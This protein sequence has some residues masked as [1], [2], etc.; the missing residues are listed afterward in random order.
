MKSV[1]PIKPDEVAQA[2]A[3]SIPSEVF[4]AFNDQ[5]TLKFS[6][7]RALVMQEDVISA[8]ISKF[9]GSD[10]TV[11]R[12]RIFE[13]HWLDVEDAYRAVGWKVFYDKPAFNESY[14]ASFEFK[15]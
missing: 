7:N 13:K 8:I 14:P 2:K 9:P 15:K 6:G 12:K 5:I 4:E 10:S 3:Q 11:M 1:A